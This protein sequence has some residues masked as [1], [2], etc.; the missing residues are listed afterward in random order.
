MN[1]TIVLPSSAARGATITI[2]LQGYPDGTYKVTIVDQEG[3]QDSVSVDVQGGS[4]KADWTVPTTWGASAFCTTSNRSA[5][6]V[7]A[8]S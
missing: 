3:G 7:V 2:E 4:G 1:P 6:A 5:S 8:V